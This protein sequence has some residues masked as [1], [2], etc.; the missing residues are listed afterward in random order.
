MLPDY[1][2]VKKDLASRLVDFLRIRT[3]H[4][5]GVLDDIRRVQYFEGDEHSLTRGT[6]ETERSRFRQMSSEVTFQTRDLP[7]LPLP[8][9]LQRLDGAAADMARQQAQMLYEGVSEAVEKVGNVV[10]AQGR[11]MTASL[12]IEMLEKLH[13]DFDQF[14]RAH[15]PQMHIPPNLEESL[16]GAL[17]EL[18]EDPIMRKQ[19]QAVIEQK[20]EEWRAREASRKLV[21]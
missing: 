13:I 21:G 10:D 16:M 18:E 20:R 2:A 7:K 9:V 11:K 1:P 17:R 15:L 12:I 6:G 8:L 3:G 14:G 19:Y 4:H 5:L